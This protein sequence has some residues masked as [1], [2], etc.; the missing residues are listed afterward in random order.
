MQLRRKLEVLFCSVKAGSRRRTLSAKPWPTS[1]RTQPNC[2]GPGPVRD[3]HNLHCNEPTVML[4]FDNMRGPAALLAGA[5]VPLGFLA[6]P[7]IAKDDPTWLAAVS[8][9]TTT[10]RSAQHK[11]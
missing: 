9:L 6:A 11:S 3:L 7:K 5:V 10:V 1:A 2:L 8:D 4:R